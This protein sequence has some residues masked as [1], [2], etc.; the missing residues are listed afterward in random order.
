MA[1]LRKRTKHTD[2]AIFSAFGAPNYGVKFGFF[3]RESFT[4]LT[5]FFPIQIDLCWHPR[6][7]KKKLN[8]LTLISFLF[9]SSLNIVLEM[10]SFHRTT[11]NAF[12]AGVCRQHIAE[13]GSNTI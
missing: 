12:N 2:K 7:L 9:A 13:W 5:F 1:C 8:Y 6:M 10:H 4:P 3:W 11:S